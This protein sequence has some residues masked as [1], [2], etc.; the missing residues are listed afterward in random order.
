MEIAL[1]GTGSADGWPNAFCRCASCSDAR[2]HGV[3]RAQA[4]ALVDGVLLLDAGPA[5][6]PRAAAAGV[7]LAG[8]RTVLLTHAH[9][10][11]LDPAFLLHR[12]WVTD[13]PLTVAGPAPALAR[14]RPWLD[15]DQTT[16]TFVELTAGD[17]VALGPH[18]VTALPAHHQAFGEALLY[19][20]ESDEGSLL[21]ATDTGRWVDGAADLLAGRRFD[22]V[23]LEE[24]FGDRD[25]LG[26]THLTLATFAAELD[27][28][29]G[30]GCVDAATQVVATHLSHHNP[31]LAELRT[32]LRALGA[33]VVPDGTTL[34]G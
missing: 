10:D 1:L 33:D 25:D 7:D 12:S 31:P 11:H 19:T 8:V 34:W 15:P 21:Y 4:A 2:A 14:C 22:V 27:R 32:R 16:I 24:T 6:G 3:H 30:L 23:V 18:R 9:D 28:L 26:G 20:V 13:A 5:L 29:R 17:A